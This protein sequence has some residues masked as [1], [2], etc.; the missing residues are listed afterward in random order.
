MTSDAESQV[1]F[2]LTM[3]LE[4]IPRLDKRKVDV[5]EWIRRNN[6]HVDETEELMVAAGFNRSLAYLVQDRLVRR[7]HSNRNKARRELKKMTEMQRRRITD[8]DVV[9]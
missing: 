1:G 7:M 4:G 6:P 2:T 5:H 3:N 8:S 9:P